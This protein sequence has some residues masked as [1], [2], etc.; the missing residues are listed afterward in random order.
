[1]R[2]RQKF[3]RQREERER[4]ARI[5][6]AAPPAHT[7][8][9]QLTRFKDRRAE[10]RGEPL[11]GQELLDEGSDDLDTEPDEDA[12]DVE[13]EVAAPLPP[14]RR[15]RPITVKPAHRQPHGSGD[16]RGESWWTRTSREDH[17]KTAEAELARMAQSKEG[18]RTHRQLSDQVE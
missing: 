13:E 1:M 5:A 16:T 9:G 18:R 7:V 11:P 4:L 3:D 6:D 12:A 10:E 8:E 2:L 17:S 14:V 15:G